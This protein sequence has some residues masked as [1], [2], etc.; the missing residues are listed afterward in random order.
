MEKERLGFLQEL[1][2]AWC[3][4]GFEEEAQEVVRQRLA[5][6][7]DQVRTDVHGNVL[8]GVNTEAALRV[9]LAGHVDEIGLMITHIDDHGYAYFQSI[10]GF[11]TNVLTGQRVIVHAADG[12]ITGVIGRKPV[13]Q[14][15]DEERKN[16]PKMEDLFID[17]GAKKLKEAQ[18][19]IRVS[20]PVTIEADMKFLLND[21]VAARAFDDRIGAF[22]VTETLIEVAKR[23]PKVALWSVSTVQEEIG[24]RGAQTSAYGIDPHVGIAVDVGFAADYPGVDKK[25]TGDTKIGG[26]P[27]LGRGPNINEAVFAGLEKTAKTQKI[28]YQVQAEPRVTGTDARVIQL[29]RSGVATALVSV[30]N[31]YMHSPNEIVSLKD[32]DNAIELLTEYILSLRP[33]DTFV[34]MVK[35]KKK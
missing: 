34:P 7:C 9:M 35:R 13:H 20:D 28:P 32:A 4:S 18:K 11:D 6:R 5:G 33:T 21:L 2:A 3:P 29:N 23:K 30:P 14:L 16:S 31:R 1:M 8:A 17:I 22:V 25:K 24:T 15:T 12:P 27:M 10:G 26:G 19:Y